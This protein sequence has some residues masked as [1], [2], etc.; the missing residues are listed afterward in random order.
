MERTTK[1]NIVIGIFIVIL[2]DA[3]IGVYLLKSRSFSHLAIWNIVESDKKDDFYWEPKDAPNYFNFEP[4]TDKLAF[5]RDEIS[6]VIKDEQDE[7]KIALGVTRYLMGIRSQSSHSGARLRWDSPEGMLRQIKDGA[8]GHCFHRAI[9]LSTYLSSLGIKSRL[10]VLENEGFDATA[11]SINEIYIKGLGKWVFMDS[12]L[13]F[14][15]TNREDATPLSFLELREMLLESSNNKILMYNIREDAR[16]EK[17]PPFYR[18]LVICAFLRADNDFVNKYDSRY[19]LFS[20]CDRYLDRLPGSIRRGLDYLLGRRETFIHYVDRFS[21]SLT[22]KT[23]IA[24]SLFYFFI[25][26]LVF[27]GVFLIMFFLRRRPSINLS[28]NDTRHR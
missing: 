9:L 1:R 8:I 4:E 14:Y 6:P 2:I 3:L 24:R 16:L 7:F 13:G 11:H 12:T 18:R 25:I 10:W 19:G 22:P 26:S 28:R 23:I 15:V 20:I 27:L 21:R 17:I 5:F